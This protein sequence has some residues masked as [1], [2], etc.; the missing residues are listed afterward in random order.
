MKTIV[1]T[2]YAVNPWKGS[3]DGTGWNLAKQIARFNKVIVVTR[4]NN[5]EPIELWLKANPGQV[6]PNLEF[7]YFDLPRWMRFWK[8]G[9]RGALLYFYLWQFAMPFFIKFSRIKFDIA[10]NLNFHN[11]WTPSFLSWLGKPFVWGP[12]GH[13][14]PIPKAFVAPV[15]GRKAYFWNK[16]NGI[17]KQLFWKVD[18]FLK[19]GFKKANRVICINSGVKE[20]AGISENKIILMPAVASQVVSRSRRFTRDT[21]TVLS[22]GRFVPLKGM[23][24]AIEAYADF[25][26]ELSAAD[27]GKVELKLVGKGPEKEKLIALAR[28]LKIAASVTFI[29]WMPRAELDLVYRSADLFLFPSHEGAGMVIPE[30]LSYGL[31]VLAFD[32][33]GPGELI[34]ATCGVKVPYLS[35]QAS[36]ERFS[37]ELTQLFNEPGR[38]NRLSE[39]AIRYHREK[40]TWETKGTILNNV[41]DSIAI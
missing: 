26:H 24:V 41:Y 15:Y 32:N 39:N 6:N 19:S 2:A 4:K 7:R 3:E 37:Q 8:K 29:E 10:H 34:D 23:D 40:L 36:V 18:P 14:P 22:I 16:I 28:K 30:A 5:R 12:I 27:Q 31:P 11:D 33:F 9:G 38:R 1:A 20:A 25:F 21:F 17:A 13:H 35:Y